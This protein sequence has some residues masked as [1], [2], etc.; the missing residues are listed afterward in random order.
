MQQ[1][2]VR[3]PRKA[4]AVAIEPGP[5]GLRHLERGE[6]SG[7][8]HRSVRLTRTQVLTHKCYELAADLPRTAG[9]QPSTRNAI[10]K[11][12][13][14]TSANKCERGVGGG[15]GI[16]THDTVSRIHA[17]QACAFSHSATPPDNVECPQYSEAASG[18]NPRVET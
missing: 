12:L 15:S 6:F 16:R 11:G 3:L 18:D 14:R 2:L 17:F 8:G 13:S 10:F 9:N 7:D 4:A 5:P 1:N